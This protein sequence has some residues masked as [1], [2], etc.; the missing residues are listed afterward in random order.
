MNFCSDAIKQKYASAGFKGANFKVIPGGIKIYGRKI[1]KIKDVN[2]VKLLCVARLV[3]DK[4]VHVAIETLAYLIN[5]LKHS[6]ITLDI[7][8]AGDKDYT[9]RLEKIITT[10]NLEKF[11]KFKGWITQD[12]LLQC[13][14]NYDI[15]LFPS[16]YDEPFARIILQAMDQGLPVVASNTGGTSEVVKNGLTGILVT[17]GNAVEMAEGVLKLLEDVC[18]FEQ[19]SINGNKAIQEKY[20][21]R[22]NI[23][24]INNYLIGIYN[25]SVK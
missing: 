12:N 11:V 19:I 16:V 9:Q 7:F 5:K 6:N 13:I 4:G 18:L 1:S 20:S 24:Q 3:E 8:G 15:L 2:N 21:Y 14:G 10:E 22:E 23:E 17:K 25:Q